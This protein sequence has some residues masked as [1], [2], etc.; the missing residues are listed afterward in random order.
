MSA[1]QVARQLK[2]DPS[3]S[4][5]Q[6]DSTQPLAD[7][8]RNGESSSDLSAKLAKL[9]A[10]SDADK[11]LIVT[12]QTKMDE[13]KK[14]LENRT[15]TIGAIQRNFENLSNVAVAERK[16]LAALRTS[17]ESLRAESAADKEELQRLHA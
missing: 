5:L 11:Q 6:L 12:L 16:E 17:E 9:K 15:T 1:A 8:N 14:E 2:S 4:S 7:I 10:L 3:R 13:Q